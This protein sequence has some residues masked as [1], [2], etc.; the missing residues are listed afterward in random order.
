MTMKKS[1]IVAGMIAAT[2]Y[3][4]VSAIARDVGGDTVRGAAKGAI[5]GGIAG[6][7][8]KGAAAGAAGS[9]LMGGVRRNR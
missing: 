9:M 7:A 8:G 5:I 1:M 6:D 4:P 2:L 3:A